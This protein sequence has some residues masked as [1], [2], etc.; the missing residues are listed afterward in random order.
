[1]SLSSFFPAKFLSRPPEPPA[2]AHLRELLETLPVARKYHFTAD[3]RAEI[4][5]ALYDAFWGGHAELFLAPGNTVVP[6]HRLLS[7][8]QVEMGLGRDDAVVP[9]RPCSHVFKKGESCYRCKCVTNA[10][11][12]R[13]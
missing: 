1:M 9:G 10:F 13:F 4:L 5:V 7:E 3:V 12:S 2:L 8:C 11:F 6:I